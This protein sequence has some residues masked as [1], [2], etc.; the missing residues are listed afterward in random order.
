MP[1]WPRL[2]FV[3]R[4]RPRYDGLADGYLCWTYSPYLLSPRRLPQTRSD[5]GRAGAWIFFKKKRISRRR[6][7]R[8]R[9]NVTAFCW[10]TYSNNNNE[11]LR[12]PSFTLPSRSI[13]ASGVYQTGVEVLIKSGFEREGD[14]VINRH[15]IRR[16]PKVFSVHS[17]S[18][19]LRPVITPFARKCTR[20]TPVS[21]THAYRKTWTRLHSQ[22]EFCF[23]L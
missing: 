2:N 1:F 19:F 9:E 20:L 7:R 23:D 14:H 18:R 8:H 15:T 21:D 13:R 10:R 16:R 22:G 17:R 4:D 3:L 5:G 11:W 6:R 12:S